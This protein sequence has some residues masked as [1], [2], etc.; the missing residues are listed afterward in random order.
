MKFAKTLL[1]LCFVAILLALGVVF[2]M[3]QHD[4]LSDLNNTGA[5]ETY[6]N[7]FSTGVDALS[8]PKTA[9]RKEGERATSV[10]GVTDQKPVHDSLSGGNTMY[11]SSTTPEV[12]IRFPDGTLVPQPRQLTL[13][14][15]VALAKRFLEFHDKDA[16]TIGV[17]DRGGGKFFP[18]YPN[19][20]YVTPN[21]S[22][23]KEG[24]VF[25]KG[26]T[27]F[28]T[29][30]I[31]E[32]APIPAGVRVIELSREGD[33]TREYIASGDWGEFLLERG[34]DPAQFEDLIADTEREN[35]STDQANA[36]IV[37]A[38]NHDRIADMGTYPNQIDDFAENYTPDEIEV[39][40][41]E[42]S[43]R[44]DREQRLR[45][46]LRQFGL[47]DEERRPKKLDAETVEWQNRPPVR[48]ELDKL[49][50]SFKRGT[51]AEIDRESEE[52]SG[53]Y[54]PRPD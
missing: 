8:K 9:G 20:V 17:V 46:L 10:N 38:I 40:S 53:E 42:Q 29:V 31:P 24:R 49:E 12:P 33:P 1:G 32:D 3:L 21:R 36:A 14:E 50:E 45:S 2:V 44:V 35:Y 15:E 52:E 23:N 28:G 13:E 6:E 18:L 54:A 41:S 7:G 4:S 22:V 25:L 16:S 34:V 48:D 11:D 27:A 43:T 37:D 5:E 30:E 39:G 26:Q 51:A 19:T 47:E